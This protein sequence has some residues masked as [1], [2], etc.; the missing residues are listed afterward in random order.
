MELIFSVINISIASIEI[1]YRTYACWNITDGG[2]VKLSRLPYLRTHITSSTGVTDV[3]FSCIGN[4]ARLQ[5]LR[6][7]LFT[8]RYKT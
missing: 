6:C 8:D 1:T 2:V 4:N 7:F 5:K 3:P